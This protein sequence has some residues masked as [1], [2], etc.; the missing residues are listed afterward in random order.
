[1]R[2]DQAEEVKKDCYSRG[3]CDDQPVGL[4]LRLR[5]IYWDDHRHGGRGLFSGAELAFSCTHCKSLFMTADW[6]SYG[7]MLESPKPHLPPVHSPAIG[8]GGERK[9]RVRD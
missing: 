6:P 1:M 3:C 9:V 5:C 8:E 4:R 2:F 7:D